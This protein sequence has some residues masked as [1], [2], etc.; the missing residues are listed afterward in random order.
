MYVPNLIGLL[1]KCV[2]VSESTLYT[3][4]ICI[5]MC[6][7]SRD[8]YYPNVLYSIIKHLPVDTGR[9]E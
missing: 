7:I 9:I 5:L 8:L 2:N 3:I 6:I 1:S 4:W